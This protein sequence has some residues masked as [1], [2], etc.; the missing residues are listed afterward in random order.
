ME[1]FLIRGLQPVVPGWR[2]L[3][4]RAPARQRSTGGVRV[5][6]P[7]G[8][9]SARGITVFVPGLSGLYMY[10]GISKP[11]M[12]TYYPRVRRDHGETPAARAPHPL[13]G[14][15]RVGG[16]RLGQCD[17]GSE[18]AGMKVICRSYYTCSSTE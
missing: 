13:I 4:F 16:G 9:V 15:G 7:C 3:Y 11:G 1:R 10:G 17:W 18:N 8:A 2:W 14:Q 6:T 5:S 12:G